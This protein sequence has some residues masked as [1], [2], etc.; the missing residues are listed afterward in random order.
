MVYNRV[1]V[2]ITIL[3]HDNPVIYLWSS[4][5]N[6]QTLFT[7]GLTLKLLNS[8]VQMKIPFSHPTAKVPIL[9]GLK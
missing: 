5:I 7:V 9:S 2:E 3:F 8:T 1:Y 4:L 6:L